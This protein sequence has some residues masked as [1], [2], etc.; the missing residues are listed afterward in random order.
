VKIRDVMTPDIDVVCP[1]DTLTMAAQLMAGLDF[2]ALPVSENNRLTGWITGRDIAVLVAAEGCDPKEV[3]VGQAMNRD[4]LYCFENEHV[5]N[6]CQK[7]AEWWVRRLPVVNHAKRLIGTVSLADLT[8]PNAAPRAREV[9]MR[10]HR[11]QPAGSA[12]QTQRAPGPA[13]AA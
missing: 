4:A 3:T 5:H 7:M 11:R 2:E 6:V 1:S 9:G 10:S 12:R 8:A 13:V